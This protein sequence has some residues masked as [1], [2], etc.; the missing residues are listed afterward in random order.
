MTRFKVAGE[1]DAEA[2][3]SEHSGDASSTVDAA[4]GSSSNAAS[5]LAVAGRSLSVGSTT[6]RF[7]D[8]EEH[9][10]FWM[11]LL[12]GLTELTFDP[13]KAVRISALEVLFDILNEYGACYTE[14]F[15]AKVF[16]RMLLP[17][18]DSVQV[19]D[20]DFATFSGSTPDEET[21]DRWL[22]E[23]CSQCLHHLI[24]LTVKFYPL[25]HHQLPKVLH[26][27]QAFMLRTHHSLACV[28]V[29][30]MER[31]ILRS[32][33]Q[34]SEQMW[35]EVIAGILHVAE[36]T[37][38]DIGKL[39]D[40][41]SERYFRG[42]VPPEGGPSDAHS[43]VRLQ[44]AP[45]SWPCMFT[46]TGMLTD[47]RRCAEQERRSA[48]C[49]TEGL[50]SRRLQQVH[51][52]MQVQTLLVQSCTAIYQQSRDV[53]PE[54]ALCTLVAAI[55]EI[56]SHTRQVRPVHC[57][58]KSV[59]RNVWQPKPDDAVYCEHGAVLR[60]TWPVTVCRWRQTQPRGSCWC[61]GRQKTRWLSRWPCRS[62]RCY[63]WRLTLPRR[64]SSCCDC[65]RM[66]RPR[67]L[68]RDETRAALEPS[69]CRCAARTWSALRAPPPAPK[70]L[71]IIRTAPL[72]G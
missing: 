30:A 49:L 37:K 39:V 7:S 42:D 34:M 15:W 18:F 3:A 20:I 12:I 61:S 23:T 66:M 41:P 35:N 63:S 32:G 17:I 46:F 70:P 67:T 22:Y 11:P 25:V 21:R 33:P 65:F 50:G 1:E 10:Y 19:E 51:V 43:P 27:I 31:L 57:R 59:C 28:G 72:F 52:R 58:A 4:P 69:F 48:Y 47:A 40:F 16:E 54:A 26:K 53:M 60:P 64:C 56:C 29:T 2:A 62:H 68:K 5:A 14:G 9:L 44:P 6:R 38:P 36:A 24:D 45:S 13:R 8:H 71:A 55:T